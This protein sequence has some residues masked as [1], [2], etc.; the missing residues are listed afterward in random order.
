MSQ[1]KAISAL[2]SILLLLHCNRAQADDSAASIA[3]GGLVPRQENRIT[4]AR[5]LLRISPDHIVVDYDFRNDS[6]QDVTTEVAFP[7]PAYQGGPNTPSVKLASFASLKLSIDGQQR[8]FS[9]EAKALLHK[10]DVSPILLEE[11]VDIATFGHWHD[12]TKSDDRDYSPDFE[13]LSQAE[14]KR[15][16]ALDLFD[17]DSNPNWEVHLQYHWTQTFKAHS[18]THIRHEY[19]PNEG[20]QVISLSAV[21]ALL[22]TNGNLAKLEDQGRTDEIRQMQ[23]FC[24]DRSL[25]QGISHRMHQYD[26]E[27]GS[28]F[29]PHWVDFILTTANTWK[30]PIEDFTL[31]IERTPSSTANTQTFI[32]FCSPRK[33]P[34][35]K[36]DANHFSVHLKDFIPSEE[37]HLGFLDLPKAKAQKAK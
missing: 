7:I 8:D 13:R 12:A 36:L 1:T 30:K 26:N 5:E 15:L 24:P 19:T 28:Y 25:L 6:N 29:Y 9:I 16:L 3:A 21:D 32:S 17:E 4:M 10:Q 27:E 18:S 22:A 33:T 2:I 34:V 23:S 35:E 11:H 20:F 14:Q 31:I 37:L